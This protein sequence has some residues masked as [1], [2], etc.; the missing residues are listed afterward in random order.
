[1]WCTKADDISSYLSQV[2]FTDTLDLSMNRN[3]A[4]HVYNFTE[5]V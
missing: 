5:V 2:D 1:M 4:Y 3:Q